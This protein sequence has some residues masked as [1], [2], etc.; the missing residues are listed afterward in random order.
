MKIL[1]HDY[2]AEPRNQMAALKNDIIAEFWKNVPLAYT[3]ELRKASYELNR[4][5]CEAVDKNIEIVGARVVVSK[6]F[7]GRE[8]SFVHF[9]LGKILVEEIL[10]SNKIAINKWESYK[11]RTTEYT[12][13]VPI[14][15]FKDKP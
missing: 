11:E 2:R 12:V 7:S 13:Q 15:V 5:I 6:D 4:A 1:D 9:Q 14:I 8:D 3:S 10:K